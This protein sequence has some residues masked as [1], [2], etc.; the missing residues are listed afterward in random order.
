MTS[1]PDFTT[2]FTAPVS[3]GAAFEATT[4]PSAW[5]NEM[6]VGAATRV[7]DTFAYDVPGLHHSTFQVVEAQPG[8]RLRWQVVRSGDEHELDE[9]IGTE[10]LFEYAPD[11]AGTR[12]TFTHVGLR[13]SLDC[14]TVCTTAWSHHLEVG[15]RALL[16]EGR[17]APLTA[18]TVED[19]ARKVGA[20]APSRPA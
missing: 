4:R 5:W 2:S 15:L 14:H 16:T 10:L 3:P 1:D 20:G 6:V 12:V 8:E 18:D 17:G 19:V 13:P 7:G 9:W 11:P